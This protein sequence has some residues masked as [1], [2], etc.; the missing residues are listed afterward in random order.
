MLGAAGTAGIACGAVA[1]AGFSWAL[2]QSALGASRTATHVCGAMGAGG[3]SRP[4]EG[5][6]PEALADGSAGEGAEG[7]S[8]ARLDSSVLRA[9]LNFSSTSR[10]LCRGPGGAS[11]AAAGGHGGWEVWSEAWP[12]GRGNEPRTKS[13]SW[14]SVG[15]VLV[16][17]GSGALASDRCASSTVPSPRSAGLA[18]ISGGKSVTEKTCDEPGSCSTALS[19][20]SSMPLRKPSAVSGALG[21]EPAP[22]LMRLL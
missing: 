4:G 11:S 3:S 2:L 19:S 10:L 7:R 18:D 14:S 12:N 17:S 16:H 5:W 13:G 1:A 21:R 9:R 22:A 15:M 20:V 8:A 6:G